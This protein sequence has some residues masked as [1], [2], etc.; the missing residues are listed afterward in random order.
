MPKICQH[1]ECNNDVFSHSFCKWHQSMRTDKKW[2]KSILKQHKKGNTK[3]KIK[4]ISEKQ[5]RKLKIYE[6]GKRDK[7][8]QLKEDNQWRCIF[9]DEPFSDDTNPDYP[10]H[11]HCHIVIYHWGSYELLSSQRWYKGFL[12]RI[13]MISEKLYNKE[14]RRKEKYEN[15]SN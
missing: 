9:C 14:I 10:G 13:K 1:L 3:P 4:P 12:E 11:T 7:E 6:Q 2:L 8:K 15:A 5:S